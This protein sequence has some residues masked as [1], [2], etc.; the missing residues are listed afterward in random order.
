MAFTIASTAD[1]QILTLEGAVT[2]RDARDLAARIGDGLKDGKPVGV[3]T[4]GLV[5]IDTSI[6]QL[7]CSLRQ[8]VPA[9]LFDNPSDAFSCAVDRCGLRRELLGAREGL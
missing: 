7:L 1:S 8:S 4:Q 3:N 9:L 6:L 5:D 2:I